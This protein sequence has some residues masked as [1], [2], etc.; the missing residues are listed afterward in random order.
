VENLSSTDE[1]IDLEIR[2][3]LPPSLGYLRGTSRLDGA[4]APDPEATGRTRTWRVSRLA[5][6]GSVRLTFHCVVTAEANTGDRGEIVN[7]AEAQG[8]TTTGQPLVAEPSRAILRRRENVFS[9]RGLII[10]RV[11]VDRNGNRRPDENE[12]SLASV[13]VFTETGVM[14]ITDEDG[15]YVLPDVPPGQHVIRLDLIT[16]PEGYTLV[17]IDTRSAG[18]PKSQFCYLPRGGLA[19]ANFAAE[20]EGPTV[21]SARP[22]TPLVKMEEPQRK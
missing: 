19:K 20:G 7:I 22:G 8:K 13:A 11:F 2:D 10:G 16:L 9:D 3:L 4:P 6:K 17:P 1:A 15:K 5:P 12:P 21:G 14:A 18:N